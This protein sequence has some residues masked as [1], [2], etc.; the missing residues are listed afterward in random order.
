MKKIMSATK[1][2]RKVNR[3]EK[4]MLLHN[5][6][7]RGLPWIQEIYIDTNQRN[8]MIGRGTMGQQYW[9]GHGQSCV[10]KMYM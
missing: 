9:E 2:S 4:K 3:S 7:S 1:R 8:K 5:T 6:L 10:C